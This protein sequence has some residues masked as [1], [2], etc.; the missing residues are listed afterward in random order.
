MVDIEDILFDAFVNAFKGQI[1]ENVLKRICTKKIL[2]A[3][4]EKI[5]AEIFYKLLKDQKLQLLPGFGS[6][7]VKVRKEKDK[8]IYDRKSKQVVV[9]HVRGKKIVYIPGNLIKEFM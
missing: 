3:L 9:K 4:Y 7:V 5:T 8:K 2:K 6:I 1:D